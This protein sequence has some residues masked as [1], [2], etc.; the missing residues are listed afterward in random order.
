MMNVCTDYIIG[1]FTALFDD[2]TVDEIKYERALV[3][4]YSVNYWYGRSLFC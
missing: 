3:S 1:E 4:I 2:E